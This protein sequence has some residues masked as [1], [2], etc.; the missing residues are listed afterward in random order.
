MQSLGSVSCSAFAALVFGL[1]GA[2]HA[3][4]Q[5]PEAAAEVSAPEAEVAAPPVLP[6]TP[7][8]VLGPGEHRPLAESLEGQAK[9]DYELGHLLYQNGDYA[10]A[11]SHFESARRASDDPRLLWNAAA[12]QKA[13]HHY[14]EAI[15][16]MRRYL[17]QN[18]TWVP[19]SAA[20]SARAFLVAAEALTA[21]L[22]VTANVKGAVVSVDGRELGPLPLGS[23]TRLDWGPHQIV[24]TKPNHNDYAQTVTVSDSNEVRVSAVLRPVVHEGRL[25]VRAPSDALIFVDGAA[26]ARGTWEG[27]LPSGQHRLSV[28]A[29]G[30]RP[31]ERRI[32]VADAQTRGFDIT[33]EP[34]PPG[35]LPRWV[36]LA[37]AAVLV[38]GAAAGSYFILKPAEPRQPTEGSLST[39]YL[40]LR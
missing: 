35:D 7:N 8:A 39:I 1:C 18:A 20:A 17:A 4:A 10:A 28:S 6:K 12:C 29:A 30:F 25:I 33:L 15:V 27:V 34:L 24:V 21:R 5:T 14:A 32:V 31:V 11:L 2:S 3:L 22:E 40:K 36:W 23:E 19:E 13:L 9:R 26:Q 37:G 38:A 16:S